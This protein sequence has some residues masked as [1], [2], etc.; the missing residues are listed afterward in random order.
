MPLAY[1]DCR[2]LRDVDWNVGMGAYVVI[3]PAVPLL[4][5][6]LGHIHRRV[7]RVAARAI[8]CQPIH[9]PGHVLAH[10]RAVYGRSVLAY[11]L[12]GANVGPL[13][14]GLGHGHRCMSGLLLR[15]RLLG[16]AVVTRAQRLTHV[17]LV[18]ALV[19]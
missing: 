1:S 3:F 17:D 5:D 10:G 15:L 6:A 2:P 14:H 19:F 11:D 8:L 4:D 7:Q 12:T 16:H 18:H 9:Q 13:P